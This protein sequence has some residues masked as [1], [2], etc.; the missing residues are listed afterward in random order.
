MRISRLSSV[1][2]LALC[3]VFAVASSKCEDSCRCFPGDSCWPSTAKWDVLNSTVGG[4]LVETSPLA[5]ECRG[6]NYNEAACNDL[7]AAWPNPDPQ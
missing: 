4:A 7:K 6:L 3:I 1:H 2:T 5:S